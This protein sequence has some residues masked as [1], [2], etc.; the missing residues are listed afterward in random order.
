M[1]EVVTKDFLFKFLYRLAKNK[2]ITE[3]EYNKFK[4]AFDISV[5][6]SLDINSEEYK[7]I[8]RKLDGQAYIR[9]M[10]VRLNGSPIT[11][12]Q[13]GAIDDEFERTRNALSDGY[14]KT[15]YRKALIVDVMIVGPDLKNEIVNYIQNYIS[16]SYE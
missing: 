13:K 8:K 6:N 12:E 1:T 3:K 11:D 14:W 2:E 16:L 10:G 9:E 4:D 7:Y 15:A 5:L